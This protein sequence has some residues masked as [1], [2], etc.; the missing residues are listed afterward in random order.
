MEVESLNYEYI[1]NKNEKK[2]LVL[3]HGFLGSN[4]IWNPI[5]KELS[6]NFSLLLI[7]LPGHGKSSENGSFEIDRIALQIKKITDLLSI[8][9]IGLVGHSVGGYIAGSFAIQFPKLVSEIILINSSLLVDT[10]QKKQDRDKAIRAVNIS[11][12]SFTKSL[13][14][15]L[16][17]PKNHLKLSAEI[18]NIQ[19]SAKKISKH[20]LRSFLVAMRDR[21][22]S[23]SQ[24][25]KLKTPILF[26][27]SVHDK[28]IPYPIITKQK[29]HC[30]SSLLELKD[31]A[32][33]SF[34]EEKN[35]VI[36]GINSF[37]LPLN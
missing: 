23:L 31:S 1:L 17:L 16:F 34:I 35:K 13:I 2:T 28:T 3:I 25:S 20:T 33:M 29:G 18:E 11:I 5:I 24:L 8:R 14:E 36:D 37:L 6:E 19:A 22:E 30:N 15:S 7:E 12:P 32:H 27:A 10:E 9:K 26:I 21:K 4:Q